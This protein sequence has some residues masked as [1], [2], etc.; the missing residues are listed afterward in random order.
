MQLRW[1]RL[2]GEAVVAALVACHGALDSGEDDTQIECVG[3]GAGGLL[4]EAVADEEPVA[5]G[6]EG[7]RR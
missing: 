1:R 3:G 7:R 5:D 4:G 6:C 2:V